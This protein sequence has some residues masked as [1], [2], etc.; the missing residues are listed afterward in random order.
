MKK[1]HLLVSIMFLLMLLPLSGVLASNK[2]PKLNI[3]KAKTSFST[4]IPSLHS[5]AFVRGEEKTPEIIDEYNNM[6]TQVYITPNPAKVFNAEPLFEWK[7]PVCSEA[8]PCSINIKDSLTESI[9]QEIKDIKQNS[10]LLDYTKL[11]LDSGNL[12]LFT[13]KSDVDSDKLDFPI[14][15]YILSKKEKQDLNAKLNLLK[16]TNNP[17]DIADELNFYIEEG[18]WFDLIGSLNQALLKNPE[19]KDLIEYKD[20]IYQVNK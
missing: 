8:S 20:D 5:G 18:L 11:G 19:N 13:V 10:F 1:T 14:E 7:E 3:T 2:K 12:Y 15:F 6:Y 4:N 17:L 16:E 9:I